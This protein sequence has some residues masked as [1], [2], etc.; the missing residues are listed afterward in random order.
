MAMT[1]CRRL[2]AGAG[3]LFLTTAG[4]ALLTTCSGA[5]LERTQAELGEARTEVAARD[6]QLEALQAEV[7]TLKGRVAAVE[8]R[9]RPH[10]QR[11][12]RV[13]FGGGRLRAARDMKVRL[14][15]GTVV[16][17]ASGK[18][19][20]RPLQRQLTGHRGAVIAFW[21]TW[22]KP[23]TSA[24]ELALLRELRS[25][26]RQYD[27]D[28]IS[29]LVDDRDKALADARAATWLYPF[30]FIS[31]GHLEM[32]PRALIEQTGVGL[33]IFLVVRPDGAL[34]WSHGGRL[35]EAIVADLITAAARIDD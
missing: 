21:A 18:G 13:P 32:L 2:A 34:R 9:L 28:L 12:G 29:V 33:P 14:P 17:D 24:E 7:A 20:K 8:A 16:E 10:D 6:R 30:W 27:A 19:G 23:C 15:T 1:R 35:D 4:L 3:R 26:L 5:A 22:C 31:D 11:A 25:G